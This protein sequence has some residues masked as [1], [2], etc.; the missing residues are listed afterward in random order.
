MKLQEYLDSLGK[1]SHVKEK[2][3]TILWGNTNKFPKDWVES[4][5]LLEKTRQ[6]YFDRRIRE[7]R[8]HHGC[9]IEIGNH[10]RLYQYRLKSSKLLNTKTAPK[11]SQKN[12]NKVLNEAYNS[13]A[14]CGKVTVGGIRGL[15]V[16]HRIPLSRNG[17]NHFSNLQALCNE[18]NIEKRKNCRGCQLDCN[19]CDWAFPQKIN[20]HK[21][22]NYLKA[23]LLHFLRRLGLL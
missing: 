3:I 16:D 19:T 15:Q 2:I 13:C 22:F 4:K 5:L 23:L 8:D 20:E 21:V 11:V 6:K 1:I 14:I 18:C 7:L 9:D 12:K 10:G 17:S